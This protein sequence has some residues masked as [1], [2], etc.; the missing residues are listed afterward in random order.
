MVDVEL[1]K[2]F[3]E[4]IAAQFGEVFSEMYPTAELMRIKPSERAK[5]IRKLKKRVAKIAKDDMTSEY[6]T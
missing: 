5:R 6:E 4:E 3:L 2:D 1:D